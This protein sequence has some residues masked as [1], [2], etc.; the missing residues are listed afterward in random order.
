MLVIFNL[1]LKNF[2]LFNSFL[3][4]CKNIYF[5]IIEIVEITDYLD[6]LAHLGNG[7]FCFVFFF[8]FFK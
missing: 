3:T 2:I 4:V 6:M 8:E 5:K 7:L 1:T